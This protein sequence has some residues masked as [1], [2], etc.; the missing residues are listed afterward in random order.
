MLPP[1]PAIQ[2]VATLS[3]SPYVNEG[4]GAASPWPALLDTAGMG[5]ARFD[6]QGQCTEQNT[7]WQQWIQAL[8]GTPGLACAAP[9]DL[10]PFTRMRWWLRACRAWQSEGHLTLRLR[11]PDPSRDPAWVKVLALP[12]GDVSAPCGSVWLLQDDSHTHD[13]AQALE[14]SSRER[15]VLL[16]NSLVGMAY[17][18]NRTLVWANRALTSLLQ[19]PLESLLGRSPLA[20]LLAAP[21]QPDLEAEA[22]SALR[23]HDLFRAE[24]RLAPPGDSPRWL[25]VLARCV[26][27]HQPEAGSIWTFLDV[28]ERRQQQQAMAEAL[29][30]QEELNALKSTIV[31]VTSHQFRTPL[32]TILS[33]A[34]LVRH[35]RDQLGVP[36]QEQLL[37]QI[38]QAVERLTRMLDKLLVIGKADARM[39]ECAPHQTALGDWLTTLAQQL[40]AQLGCGPDR[41]Q[42]HCEDAPPHHHIDPS[43]VRWMLEPLVENAVRFSSPDRA[44]AIRAWSGASNA[45]SPGLWIEVSDQGIGIEASALAQVLHDSQPGGLTPA[46]PGSP[47]LQLGLAI[48]QRLVNLHHGTFQMDSTPGHGTQARLWLP[49]CPPA[50]PCPRPSH[51]GSP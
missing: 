35:Y 46:P 3:R 21:G 50:I 22:W 37:S 16:D 13:L 9:A 38:D 1:H 29:K 2:L 34:E 18:M 30:R 8:A 33:S 47:G 43:L 24:C 10:R 45:G 17:V 36:E 27:P 31:S 42:V 6:A 19:H 49:D 12:E 40:A 11:N 25:E 23:H 5:V 51:G 44:I 20:G 4:D 14:R 41:I 32:A 48:V 26:H 15:D 39:L 28:T 7:H